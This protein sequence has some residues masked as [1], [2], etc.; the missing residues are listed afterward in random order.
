MRVAAWLL[1]GLA[2]CA[3]FMSACG[4]SD[5]EEFPRVVTLGEGEIFVSITNS[6]LTIGPNRVSVRLT[7]D[8]DEP[9]LGADVSFRFFDLNDG[10]ATPLAETEASFVPVE[11]GYVDEQSGGTRETTG[12]DGVYVAAVAF[13][14]AGDYGVK[15]DVLQPAE[16][17]IEVP[18]R[19]NVL[20]RSSEPMIGG[21]AP[22]STH[23]TLATSTAIE[24][25]DSSSPPRP[26]MHDV[27]IADAIARGR[28]SVIAFATPAYCLSRTCAPVMDTVMDPLFDRYSERASFIHIEPYALDDLRA[29]FIQTPEPVTREWGIQTEPWIFVVDAEGRVTAK[30]E[31]IAATEE[32]ETA[33]QDALAG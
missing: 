18:F 14:R 20:E 8:A 12:T 13:P 7:D 30:F 24:D 9:V 23:A 21:D 32:V 4:G 29:G 19:F 5:A 33:L 10:D 1:A 6:S 26:H 28:P 15:V 2:L 3:S 22:R 25:I 16:D 31:G 11:L 27:T 17:V